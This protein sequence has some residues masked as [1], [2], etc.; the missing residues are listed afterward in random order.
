MEQ[1]FEMNKNQKSKPC[2]CDHQKTDHS[3]SGGIRTEC[4]W[5][6]C[7]CEKYEEKK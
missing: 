5:L 4:E 6:F 1:S 2:I 7:K 3:P